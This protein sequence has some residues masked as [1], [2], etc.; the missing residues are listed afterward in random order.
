MFSRIWLVCW[1]PPPSDSPSPWPIT[2]CRC[3]VASPDKEPK[4]LTATSRILQTGW[5]KFWMGL[6]NLDYFVDLKCFSKI[7]ITLVLFC[8]FSEKK[9]LKT[10]PTAGLAY[11]VQLYLYI[12]LNYYVGHFQWCCTKI[13]LFMREYV[14]FLNA[15]PLKW[16]SGHSSIVGPTASQSATPR[17]CQYCHQ[18]SK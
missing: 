6:K 5:W 13:S 12:L 4:C 14:K 17:S 1:W 18:R 15:L 9:Q 3:S 8:L 10:L 2:R 11:K 7:L 16:T